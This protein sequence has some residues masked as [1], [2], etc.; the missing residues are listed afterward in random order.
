M[1]GQTRGI[2]LINHNF[3]KKCSII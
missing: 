3:E 2:C 1:Y